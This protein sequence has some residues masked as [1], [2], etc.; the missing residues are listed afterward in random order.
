MYPWH[1]I[2]VGGSIILPHHVCERDIFYPVPWHYPM[3]DATK[4]NDFS[5]VTVVWGSSAWTSSLAI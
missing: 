3:I 2:A 1:G 4:N 5:T